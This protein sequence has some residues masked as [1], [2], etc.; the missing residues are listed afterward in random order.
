MVDEKLRV[1]MR[2]R[3]LALTAIVI[4]SSITSVIASN[5]VTTQDTAISGNYT[6]TGNYT[7]S[8]GTTLTLK[9]GAT[10]DMQDFWLKVDGNLIADNVT[11]MSSIQT[12]GPGSHNAG[13]WD[14][15]TITST[16][17]ATLDNVTISN[18]KSCIIVDGT[19]TAK[20]LDLQDCLIGME[21]DG[22]ATIDGFSASQVDID[23]VRVTGDA[24]ISDSQLVEMSGGIHSSGDLILD[25]VEFTDV[26]TGVSLTGGNADISTLDF[27]SG[28]GNA[29][30]IASGVSGDIDGM[31]GSS[32]NAIVA[33]DSSGFTISNIDMSGERLLNSWSAGDLTVSNVAYESTSGETPIDLR[34]SGTV[35]LSNIALNGSFNSNQ[36]SF[37]APWIAMSLAGSG[38]YII[39]TSIIESTDSALKAS[40]TGTLSISD[41]TFISD[42]I[43]LSFSGISETTLED[44]VVNISAT[45]EKGIE[46]LQGSHTFVNLELNM[47]INVGPESIGIN[48]WWCDIDAGETTVNGFGTSIAVH[49]SNVIADD[50]TLLD[51][52][53]TGLYALSSMVSVN[54]A[55][56]TRLSDNGIMLSSSSVTVRSL[57]SSYHSENAVTLDS[58]SE[59]TVWTL[60]GAGQSFTGD[61]ILNYGTTQ[62]LTINTAQSNRIWEMSVNFEDLTGTPVDADWNVLGFSGTASSGTATL[63]VS[64]AGSTIIA[65]YAGVGSQSTPIGVE[66]GNHVMQVPIMPQTDWTLAA[67]SMVVLGPTADGS[68]HMAGGNITIPT[69]AQLFLQDTTLELPPNATL[70]IMEYSDFDGS[71][72]NIKGDIISHTTGFSNSPTSSMTVD[73]DVF[74]TTCQ[75]DIESYMVQVL[76]DVQL[77]NSCKVKINS[78]QVLGQISIQTGATFEIVNTLEVTVLD[79]GEAVQ[80]AS[81]EIDGQSVSTDVDG[82]ASKSITALMV[83][84]SGTTE[85]G[86]KQVRMQ[87][88]AIVDLMAWDTSSS[89]DHTFTASTIAGGSLTE[90]LV[91]EK[92]WSPY[93]LSDDLVIPQGQTMTINDGVAL[94]IA[95]TVSITVE[96]TFN[97]GTSTIYSM[98]GGARWG[99]LVIGDNADTSASILGTSLVEGSPLITMQGQADVIVSNALLSRST[100]A[101]PLVK[102]TNTASGSMQLI[103]TSLTD[104]SSHCIEAQGAAVLTLNQ[105][106]MQSCASNSLW[107]RSLPL[108]IDN[109]SVSQRIDLVGVTGDLSELTGNELFFNNLDGFTMDGM[110]LTHLNGYDNRDITIDEATITTRS[111]DDLM[112]DP[113]SLEGHEIAIMGEIDDGTLNNNNSTIIL[114][115]DLETVKIDFSIASISPPD[116]LEECCYIMY[117]E[118]VLVE[119]VNGEWIFEANVIKSKTPA[120]DFDNTAGSISNLEIDCGGT[121]TGFTSH[122]GRASSSLILE[123]TSISSCTKGIDLHSDSETAPMQLNDVSIDSTVAISSDGYDLIIHGGELN[124]SLDINAIANLYD[125]EPNS[126]S[127]PGEVM[128]WVTH[129]FDTRLNGVSQNANIEVITFWGNQNFQGSSIEASILHRYYFFE[130]SQLSDS[131]PDT[132]QVIANVEGLP[133]LNQTYSYGFDAEEIIQINMS[134]NEAPSA[135]I[136]SPDDGF[137]IMESLPIEV[138]AVTS[139][140]LDESDDLEVVWT[141]TEQIG[142]TDV[143]QLSGHWNNFTD[144]GHG[145]YVLKLEVTDSQGATSIDSRVFYVVELDSDGDWFNDGEWINTCDESVWFDQENNVNC[146]PDSEDINDDND[147]VNDPQDKFPFDPCASLDTDLDG[148]PDDLHCPIGE[149]TWL[150]ADQDDD[151]DG[152]PDISD[153]AETSEE[154]SSESPIVIMLFVGLFIAAAA[155]MLMRNKTEVE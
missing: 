144:L 119:D 26:G 57:D 16:G 147:G 152:I 10:I 118:G 30:S 78:G 129:V 76:G 98:G 80:G 75:N 65:T 12:T 23:G 70:T 110:T 140:D 31:A 92:A 104:S 83:D 149:T 91:L 22:T 141:V 3:A 112:E 20:N 143:M 2:I 88:G 153:E 97:S 132:I 9:T 56:E 115:G 52:V 146:G 90:W 105:V 58:E 40:G 111:I 43:G 150:T 21:V 55:L 138:R 100:G 69:N 94:R 79:K 41:S 133:T 53:R 47:P 50:L 103:S 36:G 35:T 116:L 24:D 72:G 99:G 63:P 89:M 49:E 37:D 54:D 59:A 61:G 48:A 96:G 131:M 71:N 17:S 130:D 126:I 154:S 139:D 62:S 38:D 64:E 114:N 73:G 27:N 128:I 33:I 7:V 120:V 124:G 67:G 117:L 1:I 134:S 93:H 86:L 101:E 84:S 6:M 113:Q 151:G 77:D 95:D 122:H 60:S 68:P 82:K 108:L 107:A 136:I 148:Q 34:T 25:G 109:L 15:L 102:M 145:T 85:T 51:S 5:T 81:V 28:I 45:G 127:G 13:V 4:L 18:A 66:G 29:V 135:D 125:V 137:N 121:G 42:R 8:H 11:I 44:V 74:W 32:T 142:Q 106:T 87:W 46:I 39:D 155:F 14:H 123:E 19:L